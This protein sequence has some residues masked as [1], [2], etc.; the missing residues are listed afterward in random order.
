MIKPVRIMVQHACQEI[1][2]RLT[3]P[4]APADRRKG[5]LKRSVASDGHGILAGHRLCARQPARFG[6]IARRSATYWYDRAW[7]GPEGPQAK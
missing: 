6:Q 3:P 2:I 7:N 4:R 5:G 1:K